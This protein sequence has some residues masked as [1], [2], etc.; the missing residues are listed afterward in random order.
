MQK[1]KKEREEKKLLETNIQTQV[2]GGQLTVK[3]PEITATQQ[4]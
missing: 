4:H 3:A 1:K 2:Y